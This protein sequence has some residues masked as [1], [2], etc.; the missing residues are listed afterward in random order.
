MTATRRSHYSI[1]PQRR[2]SRA[3][4][5]GSAHVGASSQVESQ[6]TVRRSGYP[7]AWAATH[8]RLCPIVARQPKEGVREEIGAVEGSID[9][10]RTTEAA[11]AAAKI[12]RSLDA[13]PARHDRES[14]DR[15]QGTHEHARSFSLALARKIEAERRAVNLIDVGAMRRSKERRVTRALTGKRVTRRI[16]W[17]V[18]FSLDDS[19]RNR[20]IFAGAHENATEQSL[21]ERCS[22]DRQ[23]IRVEAAKI[24]AATFSA[25]SAPALCIS[26]SVAP[27]PIS[28]S[29]N[30]LSAHRKRTYG[31]TSASGT[32]RVVAS[33][34]NWRSGITKCARVTPRLQSARATVTSAA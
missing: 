29:S 12:A 20:P 6:A 18:G 17:K 27:R 32:S 33:W 31:S 10:E 25:T 9:G 8:A 13:S 34:T 21:C 26:S 4:A 14:V 16:V 7:D 5:S 15:F 19:A 28:T 2:S 30:A 23:S 24:H 11:G 1:S 3:Q 22:F